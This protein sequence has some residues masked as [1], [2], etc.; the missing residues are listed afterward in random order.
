MSDYER[1]DGVMH[2]LEPTLLNRTAA[3]QIDD[4]QMRIYEIVKS[5]FPDAVGYSAECAEDPDD[6]DHVKTR[7][8]VRKNPIRLGEERASE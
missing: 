5:V 1:T 2:N 4:Y 7:F 3:E 8:Y 6:S